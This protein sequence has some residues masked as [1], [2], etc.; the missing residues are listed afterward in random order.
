[1]SSHHDVIILGA[2]AAGLYAAIFAGRR[3]RRV[4]VIDHADKPGKKILISG[5]GRCNFTNL[6]VEPKRFLSANPHFPISALKRHGQHEFI[7]LV[8][9]HGIPWHEKKLGQL[10][11]DRSAQDILDMLLAECAD[12]GV[13]LR[14]SCAVRDLAREEG[15]G[16]ALETSHGRFTADA[17]I[18][19]TGGLSIPKMGATGF[20]LEVAARFGLPV[21]EPRPALVPFTFAPSDLDK[22]RDLTGIALDGT[23]ACDGAAFRE[24]LLLT[25]R[26]LSGPSILQV[27]SYWRP[28]RDI[29]V[30]LWPDGN[31]AADLK[32]LKRERPR[33]ELRTVLAERLPRRFAERLFETDVL[34]EALISRPL[35]DMKDKD[36]ERVA[37]LLHRWTVRPAGTEG[38]RT[39]EVMAGGVD[40][41]AL[42]SKTMEAKSVPGL[43][44]VGEAVDV[45]GW[46][47]GYNFQWAWSSGY[48]AGMAA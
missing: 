26:G 20:A 33:A 38:Y 39:A 23:V 11:C 16:F 36:L 27:S 12:A 21:V 14:L 41:A 45:T 34:G 30:D 44:V 31:A 2:G 48:A 8:D 32:A 1:M 46:L 18:L 7:A 17:L 29:Q 3:G 10:F 5:G 4:L 24:A 28:G 47:G 19:A 40:T 35:A 9:R 22:T 42:S 13:G 25:H 37:S 6:G 15:G 43:H